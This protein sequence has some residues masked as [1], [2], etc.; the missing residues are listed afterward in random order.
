MTSQN[1]APYL[2]GLQQ[3]NAE[4]GEKDREE[5]SRESRE[6]GWREEAEAG[7]GRKAKVPSQ[8]RMV[9]DSQICHLGK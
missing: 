4:A 2:E 7:K 1:S 6:K 9:G 5:G 3:W 8:E